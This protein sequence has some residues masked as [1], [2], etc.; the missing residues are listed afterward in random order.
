MHEHNL[1]SLLAFL[2]CVQVSSR[3]EADF[4]LG[5]VHSMKGQ[6]AE[7]YVQ[8]SGDFLMKQLQTGAWFR[9]E[10]R[11]SAPSRE[12]F[13]Q[14]E[15]V[16][17]VYTAASKARLGLFC[18]RLVGYRVEEKVKGRGSVRAM[19]LQVSQGKGSGQGW[20]GG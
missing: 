17:L 20:G 10:D 18:N 4:V 3:E 9:P 8:L 13:N 6:E 14:E 15:E 19:G 16:R 5:T 11:V 1:V 7:D 12:R 2:L